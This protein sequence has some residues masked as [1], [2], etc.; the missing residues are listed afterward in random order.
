MEMVSAW[1]RAAD[2]TARVG[3]LVVGLWS[4]VLGLAEEP[5]TPPA[6]P[7]PLAESLPPV[8]PAVRER[9]KAAVEW[10]AAPQRDG[11]FD[12]AKVRAELHP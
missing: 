4:G 6:E 3:M 8:D 11:R 9:L 7:Q 1:G 12:N 5:L 2:A 10:L